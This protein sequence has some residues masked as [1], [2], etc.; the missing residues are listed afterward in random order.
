MPG[1][2]ALSTAGVPS[3][4]DELLRERGEEPAVAGP[5]PTQTMSTS[6]RWRSTAALCCV[7]SVMSGR[8]PVTALYSRI[9]QRLAGSSP[10]SAPRRRGP[11]PGAQPVRQ[12]SSLARRRTK[13]SRPANFTHGPAL[14]GCASPASVTSAQ[15]RAE[16]SMP[17]MM[18]SSASS[19]S[20]RVAGVATGFVPGRMAVVAEH[21]FGAD[22]ADFAGGAGALHVAEVGEEV[23]E[24]GQALGQ[25]GIGRALRLP[26][27]AR[28][29]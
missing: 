15:A 8:L 25:R 26:V 6:M 18:P 10:W 20:A 2:T 14:S 24:A 23:H 22:A 7:C 19:S 1:M 9:I 3:G 29:G 28:R 21:Q 5:K 4:V 12:P 16:P 27:R 11:W 17:G 13:A